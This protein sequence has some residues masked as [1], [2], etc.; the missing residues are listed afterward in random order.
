MKKRKFEI[1]SR[2]QKQN[3]SLPLR[4]TQSAAGYDLAAAEDFVVPSIWK[5]GPQPSQ[6]ALTPVLVPTG[7]KVCLPADEVL[8]LV[9]RS[10]GPLKR[11]LVLPNSIG[12]IDADYYNN[13]NNEGEIFVQMLNFFPQDYHIKKGERI[14]QGIFMK[15]LTTTDDLPSTV[16][17]VGGFG[18]SDK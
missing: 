18:S 16:Q 3:V 12:V 9:N 8:L 7:L 11:G 17:R 6:V 13:D 2:Y 4:Q 15:Y 1:V 5:E 14:C 10:S